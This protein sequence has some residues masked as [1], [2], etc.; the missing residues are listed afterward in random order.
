M[1]QRVR[2]VATIVASLFLLAACTKQVSPPPTTDGIHVGGQAPAF[3]LPS[4]DGGSVSL[5]DFQGHQSVLLYFS[6][7]PG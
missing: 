5:E 4:A 3:T 2:A 6:M 1:R 7:G